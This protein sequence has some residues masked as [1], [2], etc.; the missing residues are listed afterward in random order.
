MHRRRRHQSLLQIQILSLVVITVQGVSLRHSTA[1]T[2]TS[3]LNANV[4]LH[5][6]NELLQML[7]YGKAGLAQGTGKCGGAKLKAMCANTQ[8]SEMN[9]PVGLTHTFVEEA[10]Y[11]AQCRMCTD[12]AMSCQ[13]VFKAG[14]LMERYNQVHYLYAICHLP[15][16][17]LF[18]FCQF[19]SPMI[20]TI[21]HSLGN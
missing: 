10:C 2:L 8:T 13:L 20:H 18:A 1:G 9:Y 16:L 14:S 11:D 21:H 5:V 12:V 19:P 3:N 7:H 17:C 15:F 6:G 4:N